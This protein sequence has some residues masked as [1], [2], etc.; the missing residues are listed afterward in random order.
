MKTPFWLLLNLCLLIT[1][2]ALSQGSQPIQSA[3]NQKF[4][5]T[6]TTTLHNEIEARMMAK[7]TMSLSHRIDLKAA[8]GDKGDAG[9]QGIQG[10]TG[11]TGTTGTTGSTGPTGSSG[12]NGTNGTNAPTYVGGTGISVSGSTISG[13]YSSGTGI[14]ISGNTIAT[15]KRQ[16]VYSGTTN[17][18]GVYTVTFG[19]AYSVS[20]N[21][22]VSISNQ[23][24]TNQYCRVTSVST[25]GFT[26][27]AYVF[28]S[29]NLLGI[30]SLVTTTSNIASLGLDVLV[31]EK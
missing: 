27:N 15:A 17:A 7:D 16:E 3:L 4:Y 10:L 19:T 6:D 5:Y 13:N 11:S 30:V 18:S 24:T 14:S 31:T 8:K 23:T 20:P 22:Q 9:S 26:I 1:Y 21:V 29:N 12:S 28:N 2:N 25:T